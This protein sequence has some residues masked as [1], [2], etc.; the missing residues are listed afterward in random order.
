MTKGA[1]NGTTLT[2][3][4]DDELDRMIKCVAKETRRSK[5]EVPR[6]MLRRQSALADLRRMRAKVVPPAERAGY[7]TDENIS[8]D[9]S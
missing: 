8:R 3:R 1:P 2:I 7:F 5:S 6:D 9:F 4:R